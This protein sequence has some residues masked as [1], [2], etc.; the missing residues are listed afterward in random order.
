MQ[1][2]SLTVTGMSCAHCEKAV[3]NALKDLGVASI[4][5]S[6]KNNM[7]EVSFDSDKL[8]IEDIKKEIVETGYV[9]E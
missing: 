1:S 7:V 9:V 4:T 2:I 5:A 3:T 6:A 8:N